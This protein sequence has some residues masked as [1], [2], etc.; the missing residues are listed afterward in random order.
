MIIYVI[1]GVP[2]I[3]SF[4]L[5]CPNRSGIGVKSHEPWKGTV[6]APSFQVA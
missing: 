4:I 2:E 5:P 6:L 1:C 3:G